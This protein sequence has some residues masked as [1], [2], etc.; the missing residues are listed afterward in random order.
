MKSAERF[1][2]RA[3][4]TI[5]DGLYTLI[6]VSDRKASYLRLCIPRDMIDEANHDPTENTTLFNSDIIFHGCLESL[7][8]A[9]TDVRSVKCLNRPSL[10]PYIRSPRKI[11]TLSLNV[12]TPSL[13]VYEGHPMHKR[14]QCERNGKIRSQI[15][16]LDLRPI[17]Q[18][19]DA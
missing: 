3:K 2:D 9:S 8:D 17:V 4:K 15:L 12:K 10:S 19:R 5:P 18:C 13:Q 7:N 11:H 14:Y 1:V 6:D 16:L